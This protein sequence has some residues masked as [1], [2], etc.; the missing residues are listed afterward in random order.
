MAKSAAKQ[1]NNL[2]RRSLLT[3][4][5][6]QKIC[7]LIV[8]GTFEHVA[9]GACGISRHTFMEWMNRGEGRDERSAD[10]KYSDF[11]NAVRLARD[12]SRAGAKVTVRKTDVKWWLRYMHRDK[13]GDPGWSDPHEMSVAAMRTQAALTDANGNT[14]ELT[15]EMVQQIIDAGE[16][17]E[18][19]GHD[20][21]R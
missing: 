21:G 17:R 9:A 3:P 18:K 14:I 19:S 5:L 1:I 10:K 8:A 15:L 11:A 6:T 12:Q 20:T 13:P 7:G 4:E 2:G 16:R